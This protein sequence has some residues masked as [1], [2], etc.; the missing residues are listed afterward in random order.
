VIIA[1]WN[2]NSIRTRMNI[3]T[4]W[5]QDKNPDI[6]LLQE[7]KCLNEQFPYQEI[8][9]LG[10]NIAVFG[11]KSYNG[12]AILSKYPLED[13]SYNFANC[14]NIDDARYIEAVTTING[15]VIRV[16]SVY[17]PNGQDMSSDKFIYKLKFLEALQ[18]H[19]LGLRGL[20]EICI[21]GGDYNIAPSDIDVYD[22][23]LIN[24][25]V[26]FN[27]VE[28]KMLHSI[29]GANYFD[30]YRLLYPEKREYSWWDYRAGS[31]QK[32]FGMRIDYLLISPLAAD[33]LQD[34]IIDKEIRAI[35]KTSDHAPVIGYFNIYNCLS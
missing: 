23:S 34:V 3:L 33:K 15:N 11:Q 10:Y 22:P 4:N 12:V 20:N 29:L 26:C 5:L 7:I 1:T 31:F 13:I 35:E 19:M 18:Q 6:V 16:A 25:M 17:V 27:K 32:N 14:P 8:E 28:Q 2:I 30:S 9:E 24:T 21:I